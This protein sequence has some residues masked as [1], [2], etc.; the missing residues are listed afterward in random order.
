MLFTKQLDVLSPLWGFSFVDVPVPGV[1]PPS[2]FFRTFG[3]FPRTA[4]IRIH[5]KQERGCAR[6]GASP[7]FA[8]QLEALLP[9]DFLSTDDEDAVLG[10]RQAEALAH[11][12][13][14]LAVRGDCSRNA[15]HC[16]G[17]GKGER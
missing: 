1:T 17:V 7:F 16:I 15:I 13:E 4:I 5:V 14:G 9:Q 6:D 12:V 3:A 2:V 11:E 8:Y 10:S